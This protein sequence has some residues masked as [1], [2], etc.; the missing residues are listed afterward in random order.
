MKFVFVINGVSKIVEAYNLKVAK[1]SILDTIYTS[2]E[3]GSYEIYKCITQKSKHSSWVCIDGIWGYDAAAPLQSYEAVY[4]THE[5]VN[6][7]VLDNYCKLHEACLWLS[8]QE[9]VSSGNYYDDGGYFQIGGAIVRIKDHDPRSRGWESS[10]NIIVDGRNLEEGSYTYTTF[11][12]LLSVVKR[13]YENVK[14][15]SI[16]AGT[17]NKDAE[18]NP[19]YI[20]RNLLAIAQKRIPKPLPKPEFSVLVK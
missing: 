3:V 9:G 1:A 20:I 10:H 2:R 16:E 14:R 6:H 7:E 11:D 12:N 4:K 17:Y 5:K 15:F 19:K 8:M 18:S 13:I